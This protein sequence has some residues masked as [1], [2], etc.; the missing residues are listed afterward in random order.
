MKKWVVVSN[1]NNDSKNFT[2]TIYYII[3]DFKV[4]M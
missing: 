1:V 4:K 2:V 3:I